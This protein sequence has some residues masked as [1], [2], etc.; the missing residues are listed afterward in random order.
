M[1]V[2]S[3]HPSVLKYL[4]EAKEYLLEKLRT[5]I[6]SIGESF[7][8]NEVILKFSPLGRQDGRVYENLLDMARNI[9]FNQQ[10]GLSKGVESIL[11]LQEST[12]K[13]KAKA[14]L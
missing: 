8:Y 13:R 9:D 1:E 10:K 6:V 11:S 4:E 14:R 3:V 12:R 5:D 2:E 7:E